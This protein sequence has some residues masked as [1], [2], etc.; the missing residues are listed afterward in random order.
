MAVLGSQRMRN[1]AVR[2][3]PFPS[4]QISNNMLY[5]KE[6]KKQKKLLFVCQQC[7]HTEAASVNVVYRNELKKATSYVFGVI[8]VAV[9]RKFLWRHDGFLGVVVD[10]SIVGVRWCPTLDLAHYVIGW[11]YSASNRHRPSQS[12]R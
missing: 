1:E 11:E 10:G 12:R 8:G 9:A 7:D 4:L 5:P 3:F 2:N 6:D